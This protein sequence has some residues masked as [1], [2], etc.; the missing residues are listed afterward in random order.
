MKNS[1]FRNKNILVTG[2]TGSIGSAIVDNLL[3]Y[4]PRVIRIYDNDENAMFELSRKYE[5]SKYRKNLRFLIGDIRDK[6]RLNL[7]MKD[8]DI[9][10]GCAALKHVPMCDYNPFE[11]IKT[12]VIGT[13]NVIE[14]AFNNK[15]HKVINI[16]TDK[17]V[18]P[19]NTMG[20][21][22]LLAER[23]IEDMN[24]MSTHTIFT[25]VRF[26]NVML[27]RGSVIPIFEDQIKNGGPVTITDIRM[28]RY[29]M[30][31]DDAVN[32]M[33]KA[34]E[35]SKGGETFV[36]KMEEKFIVDIAMDMIG[37]KEIPIKETGIR[38]GE[39]LNEELLTNYE[40]DNSIEYDNLIII[41]PQG[42]YE[43]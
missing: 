32:L 27:S 35:L 18:N 20:A 19:I 2:G 6:D 21:T 36:F 3:N 9:V 15:V 12:N 38:K 8:I 37:D 5:N 22:K 7:A 43:D 4:K 41:N 14:T 39:K 42:K 16:S 17:A 28:T 10:Y 33:F 34:T 13:Q 40:K 24:E 31:I 25:N 30:S 1:V 11:A 29:M 26:G 23:L